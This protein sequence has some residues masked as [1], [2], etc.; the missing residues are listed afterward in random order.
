[1]KCSCKDI[2]CIHR[3][4]YIRVGRF[5]WAKERNALVRN[6]NEYFMKLCEHSRSQNFI[7]F[8]LKNNSFISCTLRELKLELRGV[9]NFSLA[10][11]HSHIDIFFLRYDHKAHDFVRTHWCPIRISTFY[12]KI[13][14]LFLIR[15]Y[16]N[17][18]KSETQLSS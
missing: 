3:Y 6:S 12:M 16:R 11:T 15:D 4:I 5:L 2:Y 9:R 14:G 1:M 18:L 10:F 8:I 13:Y 17:N 7:K